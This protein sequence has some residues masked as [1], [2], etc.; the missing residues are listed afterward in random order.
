LVLLKGR[1]GERERGKEERRNPR[2]QKKL[3]VTSIG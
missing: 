3:K 1:E 2:K